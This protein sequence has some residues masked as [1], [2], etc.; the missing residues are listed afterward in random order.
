MDRPQR[1]IVL[2]NTDYDAEL[3][4]PGI[5]VSSVEISARE[6]T[7]ALQEAGYRTELIGMKGLDVFDVLSGLRASKPDLVFNL[8]ESMAGDSR[9]EPTFVGLLDLF[10]IP[11]TGADLLSLASCLF[12]HRTK[13]I[14]N[15]R[16][17]AT[18]PHRMMRDVAALDDPELETL[19]YP[20]FLKL[21]HEDA[22]VGITEANFVRSPSELRARARDM[23][24]EFEQP[25]LAERYVEG[26][27][28]NVT[29]IGN[30]DTLQVLPLHEIDFAAMPADR[31]HIVSYAAKWEE[32]H[33]DFVGTKPVPLRDAPPA[34]VAAVEQIARAAW[35]ALGLRDYGRIDLRV[36]KAGHAWVIDINPNCD[37]SPDA[38]VARS[39][40]VAG[41]PY[42][43]L[44]DNIAQA[45]WRRIQRSR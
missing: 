8:C 28:I 15:G 6:I 18:P 10:G 12:K 23:M 14:L 1:I 21:E 38:G 30:G 4:G 41:I 16:G 33:V 26:R 22:S 43:Q 39:A 29:L 42:T 17:I 25:V 36:D 45:A 19:D 5:D 2:Y 35:E 11:Y 9:N 32:D 24:R 7:A 27:E 13:D 20:W 31:P 37:I 40:K 3:T 34:M 44:V